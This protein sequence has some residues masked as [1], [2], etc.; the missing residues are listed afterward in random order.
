ML[1]YV[2]EKYLKIALKIGIL[3]G[4]SMAKFFDDASTYNTP[5]FYFP[6]L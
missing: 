3:F 1:H 6:L 2:E 4:I 5:K